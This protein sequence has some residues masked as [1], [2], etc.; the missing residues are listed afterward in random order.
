MPDRGMAWQLPLLTLNKTKFLLMSATLG[1][2][3]RISEHLRDQTGVGVSLVQSNQ[4]PVPLIY[5]F[6]LEPLHETIPELL[7]QRRAPI[8][9]VSFTQSGCASIA[10]SLTSL[11]LCSKEEKTAIQKEV[12]GTRLDSPYGSDVK[13]FLYAA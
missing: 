5:S 10:Q 8:Y 6:S 7:K 2:T 3:T 9:I 13:R 11:N 12:K 4:R 1:D